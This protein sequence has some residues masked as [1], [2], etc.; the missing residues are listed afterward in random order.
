[1]VNHLG[2]SLWSSFGQRLSF[3]AKL[4]H[5]FFVFVCFSVLGDGE[6]GDP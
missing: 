1:L 2:D 3:S 5:S 6:E 4:Q